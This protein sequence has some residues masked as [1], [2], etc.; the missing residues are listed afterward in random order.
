[1][2]HLAKYHFY[3]WKDIIHPWCML[4]W[5]DALAFLMCICVCIYL[6]LSLVFFSLSWRSHVHVKY[7]D[8]VSASSQNIIL[9]PWSLMMK[10]KI[11]L[12]FWSRWSCVC[13]NLLFSLIGATCI[14]YIATCIICIALF[15]KIGPFGQRTWISLDSPLLDASS[16]RYKTVMLPST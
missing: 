6:Y 5:T 12:N 8:Y 10:Y 3:G 11:V 9:W 2:R 14:V 7:T 16:H 4:G 1:M 15:C 13:H